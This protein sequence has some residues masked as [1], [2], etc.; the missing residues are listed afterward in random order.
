MERMVPSPLI[1][2]VVGCALSVLAGLAAT[3]LTAHGLRERRHLTEA[4][5]AIPRD[6]ALRA[7]ETERVIARALG[8][9]RS[10]E[11]DAPLTPR[12]GGQ[13]SW[14]LQVPVAAR[15]CV[16]V[17]AAVYGHHVPVALALQSVTDDPSHIAT[18]SSE[19][20]TLERT[21]G[22]LVLQVQWCQAEERPRNAVLETRGIAMG[23]S[24]RPLTGMVHYGVFR[25]PWNTVGGP[26]RLRRGTPRAWALRQFPPEYAVE[27][28]N[29]SIPSDGRLLGVPIPIHTWGARLIPGTEATYR[30]LYTLVQADSSHAVNP[31]VDASHV[32]GDP[33]ESGLPNNFSELYATLRGNLP[34]PRLHEPVFDTGSERRRVL[35]VLDTERLG[36]PCILLHFTRLLFLHGAALR[37][38]DA[39][40]GSTGVALSSQENTALDRHC[41][42][43]G[44][45]VYSVAETDQ[46]AWLLRVFALPAPA[47]PEGTVVGA[48]GRGQRHRR[49]RRR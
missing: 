22:G 45:S 40:T 1:L 7:F 11:G 26:M 33:W 18:D 25:A 9:T 16:A 10:A 34:A 23:A 39:S 48:E 12:T 30:A 29:R 47:M 35:A 20:L 17:I 37:R 14:T 15:E 44:V 46:E 19:P 13:G 27:E 38:H 6:A 2:R 41:P 21:D 32:P 42:A 5:P 8:M 43:R 36:A 4:P 31:R 49:H 24:P 28:G 3:W